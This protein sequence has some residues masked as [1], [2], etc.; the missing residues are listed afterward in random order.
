MTQMH[1]SQAVQKYLIRGQSSLPKVKLCGK[2]YGKLPGPHTTQRLDQLREL[3]VRTLSL[4][5]TAGEQAC[6]LDLGY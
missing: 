2:I 5:S 3:D 6:S 4:P 1:R